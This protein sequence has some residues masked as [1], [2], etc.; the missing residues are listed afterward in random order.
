MAFTAY[1]QELW[2]DNFES[3]N[4][5]NLGT[6]GGWQ[7]D[8]VTASWTKVANIDAA[9]GKSFQLASP[10][11]NSDGAWKFREFDPAART[12]GNDIF[13]VEYDYYTGTN[14]TDDVGAVQIYN[15][16]DGYATLMEIGYSDGALY[17]AD[18][19][20]GIYLDENASPNTWYHIK[21]AFDS[22][23][24]EIKARVNNGEVLTYD[25]YSAGYYP[26]EFD[27]LMVG[28]TTAG[29]DNISVTATATDPF[30]AVSNVSKK[31]F[32]SVYPNPTADVVNIKSDKKVASVSIYDAAGKVVKT[33]VETS[34]NVENLAN[35]SYIVN[36]NYVD[37][38]KESTKVIKK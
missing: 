2:S 5:G 27:V 22:S 24:G 15:T 29:F 12:E 9:H 6:Q 19:F 13:V 35:G 4:I 26:N 32:V 31:S 20:D 17:L 37:G 3:Y 11:S 18:S 16:D 21:V 36:I 14:G 7:N 38:S 28:A 30:L 1:S 23:T 10:S 25:G 33:T 8:G 34:I